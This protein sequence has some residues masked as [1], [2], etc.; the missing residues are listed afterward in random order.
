LFIILICY[1]YYAPQ[2]VVDVTPQTSFP[3]VPHTSAVG[4]GVEDVTNPS[5]TPLTINSDPV[6]NT[7]GV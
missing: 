2:T 7:D 6:I 5:A 1:K 4:G 3:V